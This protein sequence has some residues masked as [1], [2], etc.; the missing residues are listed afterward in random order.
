MKLTKTKNRHKLVIPRMQGSSPLPSL[1]KAMLP[2][3]NW[4]RRP[5]LTAP[6]EYNDY[7]VLEDAIQKNANFHRPAKKARHLNQA[8]EV[9]ADFKQCFVKKWLNKMAEIIVNNF[10]TPFLERIFQQSL[11][12]YLISKNTKSK[13]LTT[14][15]RKEAQKKA[16]EIDN[17]LN[18]VKNFREAILINAETTNFVEVLRSNF[19]EYFTEYSPEDRDIRFLTLKMIYEREQWLSLYPTI[20]FLCEC[21]WFNTK[22]MER[23]F[24]SFLNPAS[25][26]ARRKK[27]R[28]RSKKKRYRAKQKA[29]I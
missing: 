27:F 12:F 6:P 25:I 14:E 8:I 24:S 18:V 22:G 19:F 17:F 29:C 11:H 1:D 15:Y 28:E 4:V 5:C 13:K 16:K 3:M 2:V 9:L 7:H 26:R 20:E 10:S 23:D 21:G